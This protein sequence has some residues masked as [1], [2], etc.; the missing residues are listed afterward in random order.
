[1]TK[2][3]ASTRK[4]RQSTTKDLREEIE[5]AAED[6]HG[7]QSVH[8]KKGGAP[9]KSA[10]GAKAAARVGPSRSVSRGG[11]AQR[12]TPDLTAIGGVAKKSGK[13]LVPQPGRGAPGSRVRVFSAESDEPQDEDVE[14]V[15]DDEQDEEED[16]C[17][18]KPGRAVKPQARASVAAL[19]PRTAKWARRQRLLEVQLV[20]MKGLG[21]VWSSEQQDVEMKVVVAEC[22]DFWMLLVVTAQLP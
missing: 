11:V 22:E 1:M 13:Q 12:R 16:V 6:Q 20:L 5:G 4:T 21:K 9:Q 15:D 7:N 2:G 3:P 14:E 8:Q 10:G 17:F 19:T 18:H